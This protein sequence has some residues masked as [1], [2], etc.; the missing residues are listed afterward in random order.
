MNTL[1]STK[2]LRMFSVGVHENEVSCRA[3]LPDNLPEMTEREAQNLEDAVHTAM[4]SVLSNFFFGGT[5]KLN[6]ACAMD[7]NL[8]PLLHRQRGSG[9]AQAHINEILANLTPRTKTWLFY[10]LKDSEDQVS[11]ARRKSRFRS[12]F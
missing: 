4:E 7:A 11:S 8:R 10:A 1:D 3:Q 9:L 6:N 2:R 5:P 12:E